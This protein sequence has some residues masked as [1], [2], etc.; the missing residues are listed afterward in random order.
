MALKDKL[1][2]G[3]TGNRDIAVK[4]PFM[5]LQQQMNQLFSHFFDSQAVSPFRERFEDIFPNV[6]IQERNKEIV[7]TA[8]LPG[9]EQNDVD[10]SISNDILTLRGEKKQSKEQ[11]EENYYRME[12][13]YGSFHRDIPLPADVETENI[14]AV[15]KNGVLTMQIPKKPDAQRK[16][17]RIEIKT[18]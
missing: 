1:V 8:E 9:L 6:D 16:T 3:L 15:F 11:K 17:K 13:S 5:E 4:N 2:R 10:I 7:V 14:T 12:R 18:A